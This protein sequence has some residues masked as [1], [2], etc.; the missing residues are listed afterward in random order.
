LPLS[1]VRRFGRNAAIATVGKVRETNTKL[2]LQGSPAPAI[3][4]VESA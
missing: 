2:L 1:D 3:S 4:P